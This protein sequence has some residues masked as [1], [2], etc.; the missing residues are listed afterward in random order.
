MPPGTQVWSEHTGG[1]MDRKHRIK[2]PRA[3]AVARRLLTWR[4]S[5]ELESLAAAVGGG[6]RGEKVRT[7][8][9]WPSLP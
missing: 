9:Q 3:N 1:R 8:G 4:D 5:F 7:G 6:G 2:D